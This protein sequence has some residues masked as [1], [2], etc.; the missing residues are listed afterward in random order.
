MT[1][2]MAVPMAEPPL[3]TLF[4]LAY[5]QEAFVRAAIEGAFAQTWSPLEIILSDD[6]SPDGTFEVM[7]AMAAA[8]SGPHR[9][10]LNR[11][12]RNLGL[13][14][15]VSRVMALASGGFLV[16]NAGDDVSHPERVA[17]LVAA[18]RAGGGRVT[19]VHSGMRRLGA[20][21]ATA[22][23]PPSRTPMSGVTPLE[24]I[25]DGLHLIG[26]SLGWDRRVFD[27]FG[28]LPAPALIEDRPIAFRASL[29]GEVA[30]L[31][32][33][34]LDYRSGGESDPATDRS[35]GGLLYGYPLK[36]RRWERSFMQ[37]YLADMER[38]APPDAEACRTLARETLARLDF[39]IGLAEA[40]YAAR[41]LSLPRA[42]ALSLQ[43]RRPA[44]L[45]INLKYLFDGPYLRWRRLRSAAVRGRA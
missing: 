44:V 43:G 13:T 9:V 40:G 27:V 12:P 15:H 30:Y 32:E 38:R 8:Y 45:G 39:E 6:C 3:V 4:V 20:D 41:A 10:V 31:E 36:R 17:K 25:R 5:R 18:W 37:G 19:A 28:P 33:P 11:N 21:G 14:A 35:P 16:Q 26:A 2:P 1:L 42:L 22:P 7:R 24:V 34:L 23:Y 29:L